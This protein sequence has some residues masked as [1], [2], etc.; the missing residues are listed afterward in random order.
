M[1]INDSSIDV[2]RSRTG[3]VPPRRRAAMVVAAVAVLGGGLLT[4]ASPAAAAVPGL[5][6]VSATLVASSNPGQSVTV[7]CPPGKK[8]ISAGGYITGGLGSVAMDDIFPN[9]AT[10]SVTVTGK[11]TDPYASSWRPTAVATCAPAL[12]GLEWIQA[13]SPNNSSDKDVEAS[14]PAGKQLVGS[15]YT[16]ENG[17]GEVLV[18]TDAPQSALGG[19]GGPAATSIIVGAI[20]EGPANYAPAWTLNAFAG[21]A[22]PLAGQNVIQAFST[23]FDSTSPKAVSAVCPAGQVATGVAGAGGGVGAVVVM[24]DAVPNNVDAGIAP[25]QANGYAFEEDPTNSP[26]HLVMY[27]LCADA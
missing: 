2:E 8:L 11:E 20:E 24:D 6:A 21:C 23:P 5:E 19:G 7:S 10:D 26:W 18:K 4:S 25:T 1:I 14:C 22:D 17:S 16:I 9:Q 15:G 3:R 12:P 13:Q 27:A